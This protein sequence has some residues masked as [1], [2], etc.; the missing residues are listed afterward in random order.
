MLERFFL[1]KNKYMPNGSY[2]SDLVTL[3]TGKIISQAVPILLIPLLT[4]LYTP[5]DFGV[6][7]IFIAVI[8]ILS[9][10]TNARY[11]LA[12]ILPKTEEDSLRI[13]SLSIFINFVFS[14]ILFLTVLIFKQPIYNFLNIQS[15]YLVLYLIPFGVFTLGFF[16]S[17]YYLGLRKRLFKIL[18]GSL[19]FQFTLIVILKI[20]FVFFN[21]GGLGL[22]LGHVIGYFVGI[23]FL[24]ILL[25]KKKAFLQFRILSKK[26]ELLRLAK[27]YKK[28]PI[29]SLPADMLNDFSRELPNFFLNSFFGSAIVGHFSLT[30]RVLGSPIALI[31]GGLKDVFR[32]RASSDYRETGSCRGIFVKTLKKL[33]LFS[34][35]P[36]VLLFFLSPILVPVIFGAEWAPAGEYIRIM[37]AMFFLRFLVSPL[38]S[39]LYI[40]DKQLYKLIWEIFSLFFVLISFVL[41]YTYFNEYYALGFYSFSF[42]IL[43]II[44]LVMSY[45]W[46]EKKI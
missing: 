2:K 42:T 23:I 44:L 22:V 1:L 34:I 3:T 24:V 12:I 36:F 38:S 39:V 20:L 29:Y 35:V 16:E 17:L 28:F 30:Q 41:G 33:S 26:E 10:L 13:F 37:T 27:V 9:F 18:S 25:I 21:I 40:T 32:E 31:T 15:S 46:T 45:R 8:G 11:T 43:Y 7:A 19:I 5:V 14:T 6:F 4:R